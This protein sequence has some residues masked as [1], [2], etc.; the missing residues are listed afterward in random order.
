MGFLDSEFGRVLLGATKYGQF[1]LRQDEEAARARQF[2]DLAATYGEHSLPPDQAGPVQSA[3]PVDQQFALRTAAIPGYQQLGAQML[4]Q[5]QQGQTAMDLQTNAQ[6]WSASNEPLTQRLNREQ[7]GAQFDRSFGN[8]SEV[9]KQTLLQQRNL[10]GAR[11]AQA[12]KQ[13]GNLS[14]AQQ[15]ALGL[16]A[17]EQTLREQS[18]QGKTVGALPGSPLYDAQMKE[19]QSAQGGVEAIKKLSEIWGSTGWAPGA[20][21]VG[22]RDKLASAAPYKNVVMSAIA[23]LTQSGVLNEAEAQRYSDMLGEPG[24]GTSNANTKR[25]LATLQKIMELQV[26]NVAQRNPNLPA[27]QLPPGFKKVGGN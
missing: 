5:L 14:A 13:W 2:S 3:H 27:Q 15:V 8:L 19:L 11:L 6:N 21:L 25:R 17:R 23:N 12:D 1:M 18:A 22:D 10:E 7:A 16:Q 24:I 26:E 4:G 9:Q 20:P